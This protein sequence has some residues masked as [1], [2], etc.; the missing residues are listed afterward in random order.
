[1]Y[2]LKEQDYDRALP[3]LQRV[4]VN[5]LFAEAVL[6][7]IITG[8]VYADCEQDPSAFYVVHPYGMSFLFGETEN[9]AFEY[10]LF[11]YITNKAGIR[12]G[13]EWLQADPGG[14]WTEQLNSMLIVHNE[15]V[16]SRGQIEAPDNPQM[17]LKNTRVNFRFDNEAY[18]SARDQMPLH[19]LNLV[20]T[21]K[22]LFISQTGNVIPRSFWADE[23][24]FMA[25]GIGFSLLSEGQV[26][27]TAFSAFRTE[28]QLEIGIETCENHRGK[29]YA[30]HVCSAMI[31][32][33]LENGLE[34][35]WACRYENQGSYR[36]AQR[37]GFKP[38]VTLPYYRLAE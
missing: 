30:L 16:I 21:T 12:Q 18:Q 15:S 31:D 29:G 9:K 22:E 17:I 19:S 5:T 13:P 14:Q 27:A 36:L 38:S 23:E 33:C 37:L 35:V 7:C 10:R 28:G 20:Q 1:M 6:K 8:N 3:L 25:E 26:G 24:Q 2:K 11:D 32:Y 34:P 4:Q